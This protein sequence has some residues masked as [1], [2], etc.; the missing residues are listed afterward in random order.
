MDCTSP[1]L[2]KCLPLRIEHQCGTGVLTNVPI[3]CI[4]IN[5][6]LSMICDVWFGMLS[7]ETQ[8]L[9]S[10]NVIRIYTLGR[11][12]TINGLWGVTKTRPHADIQDSHIPGCEVTSQVPHDVFRVTR[13]VP[14]GENTG[15]ALIFT[16]SH[17]FLT[18]TPITAYLH[19]RHR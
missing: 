6:L 18:T 9:S 3:C 11:M 2:D 12:S 5:V 19:L 13:S 8:R 17:N 1:T 14:H 4:A 10:V 15:G 7:L 16:S